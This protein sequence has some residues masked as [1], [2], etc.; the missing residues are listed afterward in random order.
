MRESAGAQALS[1]LQ[2][3]GPAGK[4]TAAA[5]ASTARPKPDHGGGSGGA[6]AGMWAPSRMAG[7]PPSSLLDTA[8]RVRPLPWV[9]PLRIIN[10]SVYYSIVGTSLSLL[11]GVLPGA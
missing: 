9:R 6:D 11:L 3:Q 10:V 5:F 2:G 7:R 1:W 8:S 4:A